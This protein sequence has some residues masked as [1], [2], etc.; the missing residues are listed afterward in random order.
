MAK[1]F[2]QGI[3]FCQL[4]L[5]IK[6]TSGKKGRPWSDYADVHIDLGSQFT[7]VQWLMTTHIWNSLLWSFPIGRYYFGD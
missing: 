4:I 1:Q 2:A 3:Y 6:A 5:S 7:Y